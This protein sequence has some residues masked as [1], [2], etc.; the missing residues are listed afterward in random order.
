[1][2]FDTHAH[3]NFNAFRDDWRHVLDECLGAET[4]VVNVGSQ[5]STS[6]RAVDIGK[7]FPRGVYAVVGLH[8]VHLF[9]LRVD[10]EEHSFE[11]R[12]EEFDYA[13]YL[14]LARDEKVMGIGEC[15]L[16]YF[17]LPPG[18]EEEAKRK[19]E[20]VFRAQIKLALES[21]KTLVVHCRDAYPEIAEILKDYRGNFPRAIIHSFIGSPQEAAPFLELGC[22][23]GFN[24]IITF[25]PRKEL[26]PG[27]SHPE[28]L[29]AVKMVPMER[30]LLETDC[31]Y[32]A[33]EPNRGQ[34]NTPLG[35]KLVAKKIAE[36]KGL[37]VLEVEKQTFENAKEVYGLK[38]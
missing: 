18:R 26:K 32:L 35:V 5:F 29:E 14:E 10:E 13:K 27:G 38:L 24:G 12:A 25:K 33:P 31:P 16:E 1:M 28:L 4:F 15:G 36:L 22:N 37:D 23:F 9:P 21:N 17:Q 34:R 3:V 30:I 19:Q 11:T 7:K 2:Y 6:K 20:E 8:P